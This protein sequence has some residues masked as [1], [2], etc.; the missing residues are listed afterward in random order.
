MNIKKIFIIYILVTLFIGTSIRQF[1]N[2]DL[3]SEGVIGRSHYLALPFLLI[4]YFLNF[5]RVK[6]TS[7]DLKL[8]IIIILFGGI[9]ILI[10]HKSAG[11]SGFLNFIIEPVLLLQLLRISNQ[12]TI[13]T[14][15]RIVVVFLIIESL[16]A[17]FEAVTK[18]ILFADASEYNFISGDM[19]A[20][21]LHGHPLQNAF[22]VAIV[23]TVIITSNMKI[24]SKYALFLL[25]YLAIFSFNTRSSI[26]LLAIILIISVFHDMKDKRI[27]NWHK[28]IFLVG[29]TI[30]IYFG[31][32]YI[33]TN[34]LGSR[35]A[36][37]LTKD[38]SSSNARYVLINII[39]SM[40]FQDLLFGVPNDYI[41]SILNRNGLIAIENSIINLTFLN[42]LIFTCL[43][44]LF[45]FVE[46]KH[47][48]NDKYMFKM[49]IF[50]TFILLNANNALTTDC[51]IVPVLIL[52]L[53]SF[54]DYKQIITSPIHIK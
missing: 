40:N 3:P 11:L 5:R 34:S 1:L 14:I 48:G 21:S 25:G 26:Y 17:V 54:R 44:L 50:L 10:F 8:F 6:F 12:K 36:V 2:I 13:C 53:Y 37:G 32:D 49:T 35:I 28:L 51:P 22:L 39:T 27:K 46:L 23:S 7:T 24:L 29:L 47:I 43:F 30:A 9:N 20:Y 45:M 52:A 31:I 42:G 41:V 15:R 16:I 4:S 19:R 33:E 38:D 18:V